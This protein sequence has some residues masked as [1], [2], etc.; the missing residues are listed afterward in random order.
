MSARD[1]HQRFLSNSV[2]S[3]IDQILLSG[4]NFAVGLLFIRY[5]PKEVYG[6]YSQLFAA[7]LVAT[8]VLDALINNPLT[9]LAPRRSEQERRALVAQLLKYQIALGLAMAVV[10]GVMGGLLT[11]ASRISETPLG[12][13][14]AFAAFVLTTGLREYLRNQFFLEGKANRVLQLD[15]IYALLVAAGLTVLLWRHDLLVETVLACIALANILVFF[16]VLGRTRLHQ[17][18]AGGIDLAG[19]VRETWGHGRWA[20]P[21]AVVAWLGNYSYLYVVSA[22][23]G[24]AAVADLSA[25][26]LL[27]MPISLSVVAWSRVSRPLVSHWLEEGNR[28][29]IRRLT[30]QSVLGLSTVTLIYVVLLF[31]FLP[32][33]EQ[34]LLGPKYQGIDPLIGLWGVYFAINATRN[35]ASSWLQCAGEYRFMFKYAV[36][37]L[38]IVLTATLLGASQLGTAGAILALI[39]GE[40]IDLVVLG[41]RAYRRVLR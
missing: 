18:P 41:H 5:A 8:T 3:F 21:G 33:L 24:A 25:A 35:I 38:P 9:T 4:L 19:A 28:T 27:L 17:P 16:A 22:L 15:G 30:R 13:G 39:L 2:I 37:F 32:I 26:R 6:L 20:L 10:F 29:A 1:R 14:L 31:L 11:G 7:G 40:L 23:I 36:V 34:Y 12:I